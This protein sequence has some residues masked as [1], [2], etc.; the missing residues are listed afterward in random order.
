[1]AAITTDVTNAA[2][3]FSIEDA[4]EF[5]LCARYGEPED[6]LIYLK[7]NIP[8]N[9]TNPDSGNSALHLA[10]ANGHLDCVK[11]LL[12]KGAIDAPNKKGN[13]A[14]HW[15]VQN[16]HLPVVK[17]LLESPNAD[18]L[19]KNSFGKSALT[20]AFGRENTDI[21]AALLTHT[22]A[23]ELENQKKKKK[24]TNGNSNI[25]DDNKKTT[26]SNDKKPKTPMESKVI[27]EKIHTFKFTEHTVKCREIALDWDGKAFENNNAENDVTGINIWSASIVLS[28]WLVDNKGWFLNKNVCELGAGAGLP[29][30]TCGIACNPKLIMITDYLPHCVENIEKN[31]EIN[32]LSSSSSFSHAVDWSKDAT[33]P[34]LSNDTQQTFD[35][36]LGSDLIYDIEMIPSLLSVVTKLLN[37]NGIFL[38]VA[39]TSKRDGMDEFKNA[40][41]EEGNFELTEAIAAPESYY[42]NPLVD[43]TQTECDLHFNEL[44]SKTYTLYKWT[45]IQK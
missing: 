21:T 4:E 23:K 2:N 42:S 31:I 13:Y 36:L 9:Y 26:D 32:K 33:W 22:S 16:Q 34:K 39:P 35:V 1:M 5:L 25:N 7:N 8:I 45:K 29:G 44:S 40:I 3:A 28:R 20:E 37:S 19:K 17:L 14:L 30:L 10:S 24:P 43:A 41:L 18:I 15:A 12:L 6:M 27:Q 11:I 38:Y